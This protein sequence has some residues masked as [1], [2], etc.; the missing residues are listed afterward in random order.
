MI[1]YYF[2][3]KIYKFFKFIEPKSED[4]NLTK[5][6]SST[7]LATI[8][9]LAWVSIIFFRDIISK[10]PHKHT[11]FS[12][13]MGLPIL[14]VAVLHWL[15]FSRND[16][17]KDY[18]NKFDKWPKAKNELGTWLILGVIVLIFIGIGLSLYFLPINSPGSTT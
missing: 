17:W 12:Y 10:H 18:I 6:K 7:I 3:Y 5:V 4:D 1:Y 9:S 13:E 2:F 14:V 11:F 16:K 15:L 8:L